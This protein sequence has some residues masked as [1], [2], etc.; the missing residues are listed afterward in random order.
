MQTDWK[1]SY[2]NGKTAAR[3]SVSVSLT[4][5]YLKIVT[6]DGQTL[7]WPY[8]QIRQ[9]QGFY[10][11][12]QVR[13]EKGDAE[14]II[15]PDAHFLNALHRLMPEKA[16]HFHNPD[17]RRVRTQLAILSAITSIAI[18]IS[19]YFWG[20]PA[21]ATAVAAQVPVSWEAAL[22]GS[23][24]DSLV[25]IEKRCIAPRQTEKINQIMKALMHPVGVSPYTF[26]ITVMD[27]QQVN[28]FALPG[29][30]IVLLRGLLK[31]TKSP[32]QLAGV[33]AHEVQHISRRHTTRA[34]LVQASTGLLLSALTGNASG[35]GANGIE[36][37]RILGLLQYSRQNEEEADRGGMEMLQQAGIAPGGMIEFFERIKQGE[38]GRE[39]APF[40]KYLSTHPATEDRIKKLRSLVKDAP[41]PSVRL[42]PEYDWSDIR[43]VCE[44]MAVETAM[45]RS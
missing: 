9:T 27:S 4:P 32:E 36:A 40:S 39:G 34:L 12:E 7:L 16:T 23:V 3:Q 41:Q 45:G 28:A 14:A 1:G 44:V 20:I 13:L 26:R 10:P 38:G 31:E 18:V 24:L 6:E 2:L 17:R 29:G 11:D 33:L 37:A 30:T 5:T 21:L 15:I 42:L 25:P 19:L 8:D 43:N 35:M 22:G